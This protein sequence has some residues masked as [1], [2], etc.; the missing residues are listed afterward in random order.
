M[1]EKSRLMCDSTLIAPLKLR[2]SET[3]T[4]QSKAWVQDYI[5]KTAK[6]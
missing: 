1:A 5:F 4:F 2:F 3:P 6:P